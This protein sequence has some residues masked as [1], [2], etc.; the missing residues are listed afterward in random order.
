MAK[1]LV[2]TT[3]KG[4]ACFY[5]KL[6]LDETNK[7]L[8]EL[9]ADGETP[10]TDHSVFFTYPNPSRVYIFDDGRIIVTDSSQAKVFDSESYSIWLYDNGCIDHA[11]E[12]VGETK[13]IAIGESQVE[14]IEI[15]YFLGDVI[16]D[17]SIEVNY[18]LDGKIEHYTLYS[19][20]NLIRADSSSGKDFLI[21]SR[22]DSDVFLSYVRNLSI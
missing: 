3:K 4:K 16:I 18:H 7:V 6:D 20:S 17:S 9:E 19:D 5:E 12:V 14:V 8:A 10:L 15:P 22:I 11:V 13:M 21:Q 2:F 1:I